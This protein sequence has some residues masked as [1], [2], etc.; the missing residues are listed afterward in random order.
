MR[1]C[2]CGCR[3][4][5]SPGEG[6]KEDKWVAGRALSCSSAQWQQGEAVVMERVSWRQVGVYGFRGQEGK[7]ILQ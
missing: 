1:L 5:G 2:G 7:Q 3:R 4:A 6:N